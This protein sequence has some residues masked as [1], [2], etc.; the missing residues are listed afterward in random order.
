[1]LYFDRAFAAFDAKIRQCAFGGT[2]VPELRGGAVQ[3]VTITLAE[4]LKLASVEPNHGRGW[5]CGLDAM[6]NLV[7]LLR[8]RA[9]WRG[10]DWCCD[11]GRCS[12]I[13]LLVSLDLHPFACI[14]ALC[15]AVS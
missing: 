9:R 1:M 5:D 12:M 13:E 6:R 15:N 2:S 8:S 11:C 4:S 3:A 14:E 7:Q 10:A